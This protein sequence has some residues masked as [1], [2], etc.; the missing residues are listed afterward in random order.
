MRSDGVAPEEE[1]AF[2]ELYPLIGTDQELLGVIAGP[3]ELLEGWRVL[4][5]LRFADDVVFGCWSEAVAEQRD[6]EGG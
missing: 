5:G 2:T 6:D 4:Y 1:A 3:A